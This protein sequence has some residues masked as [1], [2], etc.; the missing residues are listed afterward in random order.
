MAR[1]GIWGEG[2]GT[3]KWQRALCQ[4]VLEFVP[5]GR[6]H[7]EERELFPKNSCQTVIELVP[8]GGMD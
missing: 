2:H 5:N 7:W 4:T 8:N 1:G 6:W 3:K